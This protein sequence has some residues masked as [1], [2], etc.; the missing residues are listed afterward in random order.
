LG[1]AARAEPARPQVQQ[2]DESTVVMERPVSLMHDLLHEP[3]PLPKPAPA[4]VPAAAPAPPPP[5]PVEK[6]PDWYVGIDGEPVGPID[7][8]FLKN[9]IDKGKVTADSLVWREELTDWRALKTFPELAALVPAGLSAASSLRAEPKDE[10]PKLDIKPYE[11]F[12]APAR[13]PAPVPVPSSPSAL[14]GSAAVG[15]LPTSAPA[16]VVS[17][18]AAQAPSRES[19]P[20]DSDQLAQLAGIP[21]DRRRKRRG[22]HPMAYAFI[23]MAAAFGAVAAWVLFSQRGA[24]SETSAT[25]PTA[26][27]SVATTAASAAPEGSAVQLTEVD[28]SGGI[29]EPP[30]P[31]KGGG[32]PDP[33]ETAGKT[34]QPKPCSPDDPFCGASGVSGPSG[35]GPGESGDGSGQGL[36][37]DQVQSVVNRNRHAVS[38]KCMSFVSGK[39]G[40]SAKVGV[41][42]VVGPSGAV[43]SV[44]ASGGGEYPGLASCVKSRVANWS[45]PSSGASTTVNIPFHFVTQ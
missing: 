34:S 43:Q 24:T 18:F 10:E 2:D 40:G 22:M 28:I 29:P 20:T 44:S 19:L 23:A 15:P 42:L 3:D 11:P 38:T 21:V 45:F 30:A 33:G 7:V 14:S 25:D 36:T 31:G 8:T 13:M 41:T 1:L 5:K 32:K 26:T 6:L 9:Q 16:P 17:P 39:G 27:A 35:R 12:A 37:Q 4:P